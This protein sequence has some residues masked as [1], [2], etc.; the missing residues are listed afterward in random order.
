MNEISDVASNAETAPAAPGHHWL[1]TSKLE[2][3][4]TIARPVVS[5]TGLHAT[6]HIAA[7][8]PITA[9]TID[10]LINKGIECVAVKVE[11]PIDE[12][13]Y[14]DSVMRH[15]ARLHEIFGSSP[16]ENCS[17]LLNAL[18]KAGP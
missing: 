16:D 5:G 11:P 2:L 4:M 18:T 1:P 9:G 15:E 13:S 6:I 12:A 17:P 3:G 8:T 10:Q 7:G 14:A